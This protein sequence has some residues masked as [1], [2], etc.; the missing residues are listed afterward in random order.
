[1]KR[2]KQIFKEDFTD[3]IALVDLFERFI[4]TITSKEGERAYAFTFKCILDQQIESVKELMK[5]TGYSKPSIEQHLRDIN[6]RWN[7]FCDK[8]DAREYV[9]NTTDK[10][11]KMMIAILG[12]I[13]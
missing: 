11:L 13:G 4:P 1:M 6:R 2:Y 8:N 3:D 9:F 10:F 7:S 12:R 5:Y